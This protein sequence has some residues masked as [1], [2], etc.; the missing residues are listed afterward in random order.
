MLNRDDYSMAVR[1]K[2]DEYNWTVG[3]V[4]NDYDEIDPSTRR[5]FLMYEHKF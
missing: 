1:Y 2:T 4:I 5:I 3:V